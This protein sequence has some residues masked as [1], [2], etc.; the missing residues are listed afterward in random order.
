M[1]KKHATTDRNNFNCKK[2]SLKTVFT[3]GDSAIFHEKFII[4][5]KLTCLNG[6]NFI[7]TMNY[8]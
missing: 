4:F 1:V 7:P 6:T 2:S 8:K 3:R 5:Q